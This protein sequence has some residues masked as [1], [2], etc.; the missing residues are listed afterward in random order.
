MAQHQK[1][2]GQRLLFFGVCNEASARWDCTGGKLSRTRLPLDRSRRGRVDDEDQD[3]HHQ[4]HYRRALNGE[5]R[6]RSGV[7]TY[8]IG[9]SDDAGSAGGAKDEVDEQEFDDPE[10]LP[11]PTIPAHAE[12]VHHPVCRQPTDVDD[13]VYLPAGCLYHIPEGFHGTG[14]D[15]GK[16][17]ASQHED[18][19]SGEGGQVSDL[20]LSNSVESSSILKNSVDSHATRTSE[21]ASRASAINREKSVEKLSVDKSSSSASSSS[22]SRRRSRRKRKRSRKKSSA[23]SS[24]T[25]QRKKRRHGR[26]RSRSKAK[27]KGRDR[28][29]SKAK[30][31]SRSRSKPK[32]KRHRSPSNV[33]RFHGQ[34]NTVS[35]QLAMR[36]LARHAARL[37]QSAKGLEEVLTR[38]GTGCW[39]FL[40]DPKGQTAYSDI[41]QQFAQ[42]YDQ[43][44][45][46][47]LEKH[48]F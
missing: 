3:P 26:D 10:F 2:D 18:G 38:W 22:K 14:F 42:I 9:A 13:P 46:Y 29:R 36:V 37:G 15:S 27:K 16:P 44:C 30:K 35:D 41:K 24:G 4:L 48:R 33:A 5:I 40:A 20:P 32:S 31:K 6:I 47:P 34:S 11:P 21:V 1:Q 45:R 7:S 19:D 39:A 25:S 8:R 12:R 28:S 23:S 17:H 43:R